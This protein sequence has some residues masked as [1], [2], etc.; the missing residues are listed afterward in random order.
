MWCGWSR[1]TFSFKNTAVSSKEQ[2]VIINGKK[3]NWGRVISGVP[4]G[5]VLGPLLFIIFINDL[6]SG[7]SSNISKFADD[8][9]IGRQ[10]NSERDIEVLQGELNRM[11]EWADRWQMEF[12]IN[13]CSRLHVGRHNAESRYTLNDVGISKSNAEKD[14]GVLVSH[15]LRPRQ[16]CIS[17]RNR[18]NRVLGFIARRVS[19]R[20]PEVIL[21]HKRVTGR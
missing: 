17:A 1:S 9:K 3:S 7:I 8:T 20:T 19:N 13:K 5:S 2:R 6:D 14:L 15:D 21:R 12:N 18:A 4:Q 11:Y 10:I 16:Q